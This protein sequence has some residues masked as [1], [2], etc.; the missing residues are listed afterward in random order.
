VRVGRFEAIVLGATAA[1]IVV[2]LIVLATVPVT[3][4]VP[5][6]FGLGIYGSGG[7]ISCQNGA[8]SSG[9]NW[10][11]PGGAA[12]V[13]HWA[14]TNSTTDACVQVTDP[15]GTIIYNETGSAGVGNFTSVGGAYDFALSLADYGEVTL[16]GNSTS[17]LPIL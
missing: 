10:D 1:G 11:F 7:T 6:S 3:R 13:F 17:S 9:P 15:A 16:W 8:L 2:L 4:S 12:V 5:F 14:T